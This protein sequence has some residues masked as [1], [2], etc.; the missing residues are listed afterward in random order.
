MTGNYWC[1][2]V[3]EDSK[4][5]SGLLAQVLGY[6]DRPWK[7]FAVI[8]LFIVGGFGWAVYQRRDAII[9]AWISPPPHHAALNLAAVPEALERLAAETPADLIQI[10]SVDLEANSQTFIAARRRDKASPFIPTPR[11]LPIIVTVSDVKALVDVVNGTPTCVNLT[12]HGSPLARR[13]AER[14]MTDG[15]AIPIRPTADTFTGV[16]YLAWEKTSDHHVELDAVDH[17]RAIAGDLA[18]K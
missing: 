10:Y 14:G 7:V 17:A 4:G 3:A 6:V 16:I 11:R 8:A 15:C 12:G 18:K 9:E 2:S 1:S 13:L 5:L